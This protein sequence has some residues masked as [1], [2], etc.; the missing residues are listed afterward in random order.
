MENFEVTTQSTGNIKL[1]ID[2][3]APKM[4]STV[5][6]NLIK[7]EVFELVDSEMKKA[8]KS[9]STKNR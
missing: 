1:E 2:E 8:E 3:N 5:D 6:V 9:K 4:A 7:D